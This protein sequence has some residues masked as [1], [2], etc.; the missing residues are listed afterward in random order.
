MKIKQGWNVALEHDMSKEQKKE[1]TIGKLV[2]KFSEMNFYDYY[3][4]KKLDMY[5]ACPWI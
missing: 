1:I 2:N 5:N 3:K 4:K